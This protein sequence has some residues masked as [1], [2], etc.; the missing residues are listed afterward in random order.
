MKFQ[1]KLKGNPAYKLETIKRKAS[2]KMI[3]FEGNLES[4]TF[5]GGVNLPVIGDQRV[6]GSYR[7]K[8]EVIT[9]T[10]S[11]KPDVYT[12]SKIDSMLRDFVEGD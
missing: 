9:I 6:K 2:E 1:Y 5:S 7:I 4:G 8:D 3:L 11:K 12:W 10:V